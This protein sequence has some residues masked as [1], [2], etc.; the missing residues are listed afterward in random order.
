MKELP[1]GHPGFT[2][3]PTWLIGQASPTELAILLAIQEAP[4]QCISLANLASKAGIGKSTLCTALL[5]LKNRGWLTRDYTYKGDGGNGPN[6]YILTIWDHSGTSAVAQQ[7]QPPQPER[8][9]WGNGAVPISLMAA[10]STKKGALFVYLALQLLETPTIN[11]I[12]TVCRM[13]SDDVR[14][15]LKFLEEDGWIQRIDR[16]GATS[17]FRVFYERV[18]ARRG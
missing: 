4:D 18:G 15:A 2:S 11:T 3:I 6:R 14:R 7:E 1:A 10:C 12:S 5:G 9:E 17:L 8:A 16:P 13:A